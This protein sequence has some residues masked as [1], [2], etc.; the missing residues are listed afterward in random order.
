MRTSPLQSI[1]VRVVLPVSVS[2]VI[3][4][5]TVASSIVTF[6]VV[7][8]TERLPE[9]LSA[10]TYKSP[11][12]PSVLKL[13]EIT[14]LSSISPV[15]TPIF[16]SPLHSTFSRYTSPVLTSTEREPQPIL[17]TR[18]SPVLPLM[19][20]ELDTEAQSSVLPV[21]RSISTFLNEKSFGTDMF[22]VSSSI[23]REEYAFSVRYISRV[24][25]QKLN[26]R[27]NHRLSSVAFILNA[28]STTDTSYLIFLTS[29]DTTYSFRHR[30]EAR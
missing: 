29:Y 21:L 2:V 26:K 30:R 13:A 24:A 22:P 17:F 3:S 8:F 23:D 11:V 7:L 10:F 14:F 4:P 18:T 28:P 15:L 27:S 9:E 5:I 6:P 12:S 25:L 20:T 1:E 19:L 16:I